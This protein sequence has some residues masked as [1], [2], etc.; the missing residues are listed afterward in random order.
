MMAVHTGRNLLEAAREMPAEKYGFKPTPAHLSFGEL[1][2][3]IEGDSRTTCGAFAGSPVPAEQKLSAREDKSTLVGA[4]ERAVGF[5]DTALAHA[6][7]ANLGDR[8]S[9]Y[10]SSTTRA[11]AMVGLLADWTDHYAQEAMYLRLNGLVPPS[12]RR[13]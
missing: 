8:V 5:C 9:W 2:V 4:L 3:H 11:M 6:K 10:G 13:Q 12:A 1:I 7:D